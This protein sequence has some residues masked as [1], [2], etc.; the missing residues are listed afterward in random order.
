MRNTVKDS[1][2]TGLAKDHK[3]IEYPK[4]DGVI[5]FDLLTNL[6]R[7]GTSHDDQ[8]SHLKVKEELQHVPTEISITQY[9]APESRFCPA[10]VYE[11][12]E[13]DAEG[14]RHLIIN[15]Q[16]CQEAIC[17]LRAG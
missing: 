15:S 10:G 12:G 17:S 1:D 13:P 4:P 2:K 14:R 8:P 3:P 5:S 16:V 11:Y 9:A 7:S 6:Q